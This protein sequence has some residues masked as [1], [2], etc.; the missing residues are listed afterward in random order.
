MHHPSAPL[1]RHHC[2]IA[3]VSLWWN[4]LSFKAVSSLLQW[5]DSLRD[6]FT[7][8]ITHINNNVSVFVLCIRIYKSV[9][10]TQLCC[11]TLT[12]WTNHHLDRKSQT[13]SN[14]QMCVFFA[15][16]LAVYIRITHRL[17]PPVF[18][19]SAPMPYFVGVH[20]SLLE[21]SAVPSSSSMCITT[22]NS[23]RFIGVYEGR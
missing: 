20:L 13:T 3:L 21:V 12:H 10:F 8:R 14:V 16:Y 11:R 22:P 17:V 7:N 23:S 2:C 18:S 19:H 6:V 15:K 9:Y 5:C 1:P 4:H